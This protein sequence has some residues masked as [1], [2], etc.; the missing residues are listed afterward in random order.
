[1]QRI[2]DESQVML[3]RKRGGHGSKVHLE[4]ESIRGIDKR[5]TL[6]ADTTEMKVAVIM[7]SEDSCFI[8]SAWAGVDF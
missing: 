7:Q 3:L 2:A 6:E 4:E 1:M 8:P 5:V